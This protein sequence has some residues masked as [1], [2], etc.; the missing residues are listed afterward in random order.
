MY[1]AKAP[2][3]IIFKPRPAALELIVARTNSKASNIRDPVLSFGAKI[4]PYPK[5]T[6]VYIS[7]N[8]PIINTGCG[9]YFL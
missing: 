5:I 7:M 9:L 6:A 3:A 2:T 4:C 8:P 1:L